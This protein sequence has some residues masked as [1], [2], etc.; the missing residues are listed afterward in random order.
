M[1][2]PRCKQG[3]IRQSSSAQGA[4]TLV[5]CDNPACFSWFQATGAQLTFTSRVTH[6]MSR[7]Y[8]LGT[9]RDTIKHWP[10]YKP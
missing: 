6:V 7:Q 5:A 8:Q 2:C 9:S 10:E 1:E 3:V 4:K